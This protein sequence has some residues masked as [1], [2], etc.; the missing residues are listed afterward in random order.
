MVF[1]FNIVSQSS[2]SFGRDRDEQI[3]CGETQAN[4][5]IIIHPLESTFFVSVFGVFLT[6]FF[7]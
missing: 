1:P 3:P 6:S 2:E 5:G 7:L 4:G